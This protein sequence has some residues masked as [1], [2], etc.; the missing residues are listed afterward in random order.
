MRAKLFARPHIPYVSSMWKPPS[1]A[2]RGI[3]YEPEH[4]PSWLPLATH[5][6]DGA[7]QP[8]THAPLTQNLPP[9][10]CDVDKHSTHRVV[11][12]SSRQYGVAPPQ[13]VQFA[14]HF[15]AVL[16][17]THP[18]LTHSLYEPHELPVQMQPLPLHVGVWPLHAT[19]FGPQCALTLHTAHEFA[20]HQLPLAQWLS[21]K[22]STHEVAALQ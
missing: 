18:P 19:Q 5:A 16:H 20:L 2:A 9:V 22:Q 14:P 11:E 12:P 8:V 21:I 4:V 3:V 7:G 17:S 6:A 13:A 10:H 15:V 1:A